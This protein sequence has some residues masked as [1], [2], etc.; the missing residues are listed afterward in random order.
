MESMRGGAIGMPNRS[1]RIFPATE[2]AK[3]GG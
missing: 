1:P 3:N 2:A